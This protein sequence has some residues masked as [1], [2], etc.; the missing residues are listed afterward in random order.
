MIFAFINDNIVKEIISVSDFS[1]IAMK[2][3]E[4]QHV[5]DITE[6]IPQPSVGWLFQDGSLKNP[7]GDNYKKIT[8]LAFRNR[9][10]PTE[11]ATLY[12]VAATPQ[13]LALKIYLDDMSVASFIDLSRTDTIASLQYLVS[14]GLL[15]QDRMNTILNA[16]IQEHE[17][18]KEGR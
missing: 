6:S 3:R 11:K 10:T 12:T 1:E 16:E 7:S 5:I 17:L 4:F 2:A 8:K 15:T 13:G 18:Y 9:F 14:L